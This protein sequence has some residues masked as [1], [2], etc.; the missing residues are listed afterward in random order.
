MKTKLLLSL[1]AFAFVSQTLC[2]QDPRIT[3][4]FTTYSGKYAR[5]FQTTAAETAGTSS[6]TWSRGAGVQS[7]PTYSG[8]HEVSYSAS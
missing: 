7:S 5:L 6:T 3:S 8:V 4:R 2:A 1:L